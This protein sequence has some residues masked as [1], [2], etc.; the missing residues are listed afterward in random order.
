MTNLID[1]KHGTHN[2]Y[3]NRTNHAATA[4]NTANIYNV[5]TTNKNRQ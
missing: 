4:I 2:K 5:T 3:A 1:K